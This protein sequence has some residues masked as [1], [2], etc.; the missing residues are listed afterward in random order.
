M[1]LPE[2]SQNNAEVSL[3]GIKKSM[4]CGCCP[5]DAEIGLAIT[6]SF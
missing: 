6:C 2:S 3:E 4:W 5:F 1:S